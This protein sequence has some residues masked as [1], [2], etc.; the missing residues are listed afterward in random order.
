MKPVSDSGRE[1]IALIIL[2]C[3]ALLAHIFFATFNWRSGFL[4]GH[5]FRQTHT[6]LIAYYIDKENNFSVPYSTPLF[7]KPWAVPMEFPL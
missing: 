2:F 6:A 3:A 4:P 5:E 1:N 7:G